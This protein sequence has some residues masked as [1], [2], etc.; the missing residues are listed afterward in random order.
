M[1]YIRLDEDLPHSS[2]PERLRGGLAKKLKKAEEKAKK[3]DDIALARRLSLAARAA[4]ELATMMDMARATRTLADYFP[5]TLLELAR[6]GFSL[7]EVEIETAKSW[8]PKTEAFML[9]IESAWKQIDI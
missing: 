5:E 1:G 9:T 2:V 3:I 7:M 8:P 4:T 6:G